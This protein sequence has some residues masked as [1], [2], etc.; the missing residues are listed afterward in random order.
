M[1]NPKPEGYIFGRP[2]K[3]DPSYCEKV[4]DYL[5]QSVDEWDEYHKTRGDK[6]DTYERTLKVKLPSHEGF[7][8]YLG[9]IVQTLIN[10]SEEYP[11]FLVALRLI[12]QAQKERLANEGLAGTYS[13]LIAKLILSSNHGMRE[14]SDFTSDDE[15]IKNINVSITDN[16]AKKST[17][18]QP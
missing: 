15:K 8:I 2:T 16:N 9:V 12:D 14:R 4:K 7:A 13:P 6:S 3:Y 17:E 11:D 10:W 5:A 1:E 18:G